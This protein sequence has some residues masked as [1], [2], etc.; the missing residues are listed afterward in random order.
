[1]VAC[2]MAR[3]VYLDA[4]PGAGT[5]QLA[6][7]CRC[8]VAVCESGASHQ[9]MPPAPTCHAAAPHAGPRKVAPGKVRRKRGSRG[10]AELVALQR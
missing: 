6:I 5:P 2:K 1:M 4:A 8:I 3:G 10:L 7:R 9:R